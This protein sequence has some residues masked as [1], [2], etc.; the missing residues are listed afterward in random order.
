MK[1]MN[2]DAFYRQHKDEI[3][4][5]RKERTLELTPADLEQATEA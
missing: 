2:Y 5:M 3:D 4:K 1:E